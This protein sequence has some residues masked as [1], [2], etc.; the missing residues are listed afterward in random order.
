MY[1]LRTKARMTFEAGQA[2]VSVQLAGAKQVIE[3]GQIYLIKEP[4]AVE[5]RPAG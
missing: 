2:A 5:A 1:E 4:K 3:I